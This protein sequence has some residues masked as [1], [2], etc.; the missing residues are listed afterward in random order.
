MFEF[1]VESRYALFEARRTKT[2]LEKGS[3][4]A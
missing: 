1:D 3:A 2:F 4:T